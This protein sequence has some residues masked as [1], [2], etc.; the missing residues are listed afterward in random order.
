KNKGQVVRLRSPQTPNRFKTVESPVFIKDDQTPLLAQSAAGTASQQLA[1]TTQGFSYPQDQISHPPLSRTRTPKKNHPRYLF[2]RQDR[3]KVKRRPPPPKMKQYVWK[4]YKEPEHKPEKPKPKQKPKPAPKLL[5][6][7]TAMTDKLAISRL[8]AYQHPTTA[9]YVGTLSANIKRVLP[10][11]DNLQHKVMSVHLDAARE[12][13]YI[14]REAQ[15][16]IGA[17]IE[18]LD[19]ESLDTE[20]RKFLDLI[21]PRV[22]MKNVKTGADGATEEDEDGDEIAGIVDEDN[23]EED[24]SEDYTDLGESGGD[25]K[26]QRLFL[27]SFL[28]Y[29]YSGNRPS[30]IEVSRFINR[31]KGLG[32]HNPRSQS[33]INRN[34]LFPPSDLMR[35]VA[36]QLKVELKQ[37]YKKG[38][39]I[40]HKMLKKRIDKGQLD[41][42]K[43]VINIRGDLS[44][45]EN[46]LALNKLSPNPRRI[47]PM[48][49][50]KQ[51][52][53]GFTE[54]ELAGF[55]FK[56]GG[57]LKERLVE[58]A[59]R[60]GVY[61][62]I[63]DVRNWIGEKE[64]GFLIKQF[65]ADIDPQ[66][67]RGRQKRKA[68]RRAKIKVWT[69]DT[70]KNHLQ[71]LEEPGFH[72]G[73]YTENGYISRGTVLTDGFGLYLLAF[74]LKELQ[75]VWFRRLPDDRLLPRITSTVGGTDYYLQEIRNIIRTK[76][77]IKELWVHMHISQKT[78]MPTTTL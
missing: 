68:G 32:L 13:V 3:T 52:Y 72:P 7:S 34:M 61:P 15:R 18:S 57:A 69:L 60:D 37:M 70:L 1:T 74:K 29:L 78:Q 43:E 19:A 55:Y 10:S 41:K 23:A 40:L 47:V 9:L 24:D 39:C 75:S 33:D 8:M 48:T 62:T 66:N 31:L 73:N 35:S 38:T 14:K 77:D 54:Q 2:K 11:Q 4:P 36:Q 50:L 21:C 5:S 51:P 44:A 17:F 49:S 65:V 46:Y 42:S 6:D 59:R 64:P 28:S 45:I 27:S 63:T 22:S 53:V 25:D 56:S 26:P 20:D 30:K 16:L 58:L 67:F 76:E 71:K 12:S